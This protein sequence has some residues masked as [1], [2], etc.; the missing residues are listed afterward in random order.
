[1]PYR[2][3]TVYQSENNYGSSPAFSVPNR[4]NNSELRPE[5]TSSYEVGLDL[6]FWNNRLGIDVTYYDNETT[7]QIIPLDVSATSGFA[8][9]IVNAGLVTN[10]GWE[11]M[12]TG[13]PI[14]TASGFSWDITANWARNRNQVVELAEGQNNFL[15]ASWGPSINARVG[16]PYGTIVTEAFM[17]NE[18]GDRVVGEDGF[19]LREIDQVVGNIMPDFTG[20]VMNQ[21]S[22]KGIN[23]SALVDFQKGGNLY[24]VTNRYGEYSGLLASTVGN[25][26][27]GNPMRDPVLIND[28]GTVDPNSGGVIADGVMNV[29]TEENPVYEQNTI[30]TAANEYFQR[31]RSIR[32][33]YVYDASFVKLREVRIGYTFPKALYENIPVQSISLAFVGRNLAL[34]H[35]NI[36]N[37]DPEAA[38]GSGNIQGF[39]NGQLPSIR[40]LGFNLNIK[41]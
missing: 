40:S 30:P 19:Y 11:V 22:F 14:E 9:A 3:A 33:N 12:V 38:L 6:R 17:L 13:T 16:E 32:E 2:L 39:E 26:S 15:I 31:L 5:I 4:L 34:L 36:P 28:D 10:R 21:F 24:S 27:L 25:N 41:L 37:V 29:G 35:S 18:D 1:D 23:V 20:G 7:D 8:D